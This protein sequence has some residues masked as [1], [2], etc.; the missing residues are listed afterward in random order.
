LLRT[1]TSQD[2]TVS[3][4]VYRKYRN[5][6]E[7]V[8][9]QCELDSHAETC[10]VGAN[11]VVLEETGQKVS[12]SASTDAHRTFT[13]VPIVTAATAYDDTVTGTTYILIL[14]RSIYMAD[15]MNCTLLCLNQMRKSLICSEEDQEIHITLHLNG[16]TSFFET[17]TFLDPD[18]S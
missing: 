15:T 7:T 6:H 11:C 14:G 8:S 13:N 17:R 5:R 18:F 1:V 3:K 16:V 4:V 2:R 9:G 10:V 12:V